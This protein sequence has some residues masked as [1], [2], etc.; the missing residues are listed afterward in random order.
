MRF[1]RCSYMNACSDI[2]ILFEAAGKRS[3]KHLQLQP[4]SELFCFSHI[5]VERNTLRDLVRSK[6]SPQIGD[7]VYMP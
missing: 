5:R 7:L 1:E 3:R 4:V 2:Y 6:H